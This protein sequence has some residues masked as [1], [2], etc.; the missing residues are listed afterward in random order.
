[1][2][3]EFDTDVLRTLF[4][5]GSTPR[6]HPDLVKAFFRVMQIIS[7]AAD[8]RVLRGFKGLHLEKLKGVRRDEYSVRLNDQFRLVFQIAHDVDGSAY[9]LIRA[10]EDYH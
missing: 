8:E 2:D 10:I 4:A 9:L 6:L 7:D 5:T 3:F 1:M